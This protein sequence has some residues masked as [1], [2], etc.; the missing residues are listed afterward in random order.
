MLEL[1]FYFLLGASLITHDSEWLTERGQGRDWHRIG[2][3]KVKS[4]S[5]QRDSSFQTVTA[6]NHRT[7]ALVLVC[8]R[9]TFRAFLWF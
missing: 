1:S 6:N 3:H 7:G 8:H 2:P 5:G 4:D 9:S